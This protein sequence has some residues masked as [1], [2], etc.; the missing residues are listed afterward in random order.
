MSK[1][2]SELLIVER[3]HHLSWQTGNLRTYRRLGLPSVPHRNSFRRGDLGFE[4][5]HGLI[6][7]R[8]SFSRRL[9]AEHILRDQNS[10]TT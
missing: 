4:D 5:M 3:H 1:C 9:R 7:L 10:N 2:E 8:L 6:A